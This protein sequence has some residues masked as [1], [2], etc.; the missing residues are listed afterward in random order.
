MKRCETLEKNDVDNTTA[1]DTKA[2]LPLF[3]HLSIF[4]LADKVSR[5]DMKPGDK[6][7]FFSSDGDGT[8]TENVVWTSPPI[9]GKKN[10]KKWT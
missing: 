6:V 7:S 4:E 5:K 10:S 1:E 8:I 2:A 9:L 3:R